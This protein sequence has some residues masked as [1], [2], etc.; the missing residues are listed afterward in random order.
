[1]LGLIF[2][3]WTTNWAFFVTLQIKLATDQTL[4]IL[5]VTITINSWYFNSKKQALL[6]N[7]DFEAVNLILLDEFSGLDNK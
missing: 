2:E 5:V 7:F 6:I 1:M 3:V 4:T